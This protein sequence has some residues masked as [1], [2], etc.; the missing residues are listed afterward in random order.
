[1]NDVIAANIRN[2]ERH[3][4]SSIRSDVPTA[5]LGRTSSQRWTSY[6]SL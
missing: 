1:V 3:S 6:R 4:K 2:L 5:Y